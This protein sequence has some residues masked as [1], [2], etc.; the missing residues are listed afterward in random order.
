MKFNLTEDNGTLVGSV[1]M[2]NM[3]VGAILAAIPQ[4]EAIISKMQNVPEGLS[5]AEDGTPIKGV[6]GQR[7][8]DMTEGARDTL[9]GISNIVRQMKGHL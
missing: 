9:D 8:R 2:L 3:L 5:T 6:E 4:G 1:H 7:L